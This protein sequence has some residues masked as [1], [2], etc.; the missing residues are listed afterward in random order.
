MAAGS[1]L[2]KIG[3]YSLAKLVIMVAGLV[4]YPILTRVLTPSEYGVMGLI[5]TM[6]NLAIGVSKLGLQ[7]STVRM[8]AQWEDDPKGQERFILSFFL[9]TTTASVTAT[10]LYDLGNLLLRAFIGQELL[11]FILLSSPLIVMRSLQSYGLAQLNASQRSRAYAVFETA[12]AYVTMIAAVLG[13]TVVIGGLRGYYYGLVLGETLMIAALMAFILRGTRLRRGNLDFPL[14]KDAVKFGF[15]MSLFEMSGVL[16]Y[17][18]DRFIILWLL[19]KA[20]LGYYTVAHNLAVYINTIFTMPVT[21]AVTPAVTS[22]YERDG[23]DAASVFLGR[24]SRYFFMFAFAAVAGLLMTC[25]DLL[26][27]LASEKFLPGAELVPVLTA[28]LL[29]TGGREILGAGMF[30]KK[31]PWL[32]ARINVMGAVLNAG[33]NLV[34]IPRLGIQGAAVATLLT[35]LAITVM[36]WVRGSRLV[37]APLSLGPMVLHATLATAMAGAIYF[38]DPGAGVLRLLMRIAA[39][40]VI[41]AGLLLALDGEARALGKKVL[42]KFRSSSTN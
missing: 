33:L 40:M 38:I 18:G 41:Y 4:S 23:S 17:T 42:G 1:V 8:W 30:L 7:F 36:F 9:A 32:M 27:L 28:G 5:I 24:A 2:K 22:I 14:I 13:A 25:R 11:F 21:M 37:K 35:Q 39:G 12:G 10:V 3:H 15:P 19:N 16:F 6:L 29:F 31:R 34:L 26:E 20:Q